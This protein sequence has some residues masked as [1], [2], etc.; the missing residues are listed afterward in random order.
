LAWNVPLT[1]KSAILFTPGRVQP[2]EQFRD[3]RYDSE[4]RRY[5]W[6]AQNSDLGLEV[7]HL[8]RAGRGLGIG[9]A[10]YHTRR[11]VLGNNIRIL[12]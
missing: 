1:L 5:Q 9:L 2:Q 7:P 4:N 10:A 3:I 12:R 11:S 8:N 6:T